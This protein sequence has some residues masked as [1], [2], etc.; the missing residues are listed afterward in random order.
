MDLDRYVARHDAS[1]RRLEELTRRAGRP[2]ALTADEVD[3]L[4]RGYQVAA[5]QLSY[6]RTH[7]ADPALTARLT[8]LVA[9]AH[10]AVHGVR[11]SSG[12]AGVLRFLTR[13]FPEAVWSGRRFLVVS[14]A[15]LFV[16]AVVMAVWLGVSPQAVEATASEA[17]REAYVNEEFSS[18][19]SSDPA[20]QFSSEVFV[21]NVRVAVL[22]FAL[23]IAGC[24]GTAWVLAF[25]GANVG[26][27]A[28]LFADV[29]R[30]DVFFGL[31]LP[32]GLLEL[33]AIVV[34]GAAGLRMGWALIA[35]GDRRRADALTAE[36]RQAVA[37]VIGLV[38]AFAV[39]GLIEGYVTGR[40]WPTSARVGI[41][42]AAASAFW[43][44]VVV[45]GRHADAPSAAST[46]APTA[47][48]QSRP[49][50]FTAR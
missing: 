46:S 43:A 31:I 49:A 4:V 11:R 20:A 28:G 23:G 16:P 3:E 1:W 2:R 13:T 26:V 32:H 50:A 39:A 15:L 8:L 6:V 12:M 44:W 21:N 22:A 27:A 29:G 5:T 34:A 35:P 36:S 14:A 10:G 24:L 37:V 19:Y 41:G 48:V 25:N 7:A 47:A 17:A 18:Y 42:V 33:S 9:D 40:G 30:L 45:G 38:L